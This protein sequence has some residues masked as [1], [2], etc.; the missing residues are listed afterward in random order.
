MKCLI[1]AA[2][3]GSRLRQKGNCK[4]LIPVAG[5]PLIDHV[6]TNLAKSKIDSVFVITG[7]ERELLE[8]HLKTAALRF[9]FP[10]TT[11]YNESWSKPNGISVLKA[12]EVLHEPFLLMMADHLFD[13]SNI[14]KLQETTL[15][16]GT[17][18]LAV[19]F[20]L[21]NPL[22]DLEDVTRV[23]A[24][25]GRL[26]EIGKGLKP[27]NGYD[28]GLFLADPELFGALL[29][30]DR[31]SGDD[32]LSGGVRWLCKK[33]RVEAIDVSGNFWMDVDDPSMLDL[34]NKEA[35]KIH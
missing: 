18:R 4:P 30:S 16:P 12:R 11:L 32:S 21:E 27:Y 15:E 35:G 34:A 23:S 28:T 9:P 19:D 5:K 33:N 24:K 22:V 14:Q 31:E 3:M 1:L 10:I 8:N 20:N 13:S 26:Q 2:G 25:A 29:E 7:Y 6:L 17:V